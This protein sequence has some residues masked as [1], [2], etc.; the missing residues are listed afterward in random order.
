MNILIAEDNLINQLLIKILM[1]N[2][3]WKYTLVENGFEAIN[4]CRTGSFDAILMDI[5]MPLLNGI[6]AARRIRTFNKSIP[7]I[8]VTAYNNDHNRKQCHLAGMDAFIEKPAKEEE[9]RDIVTRFIAIR[10]SR[11]NESD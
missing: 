10:D 2:L 1:S 6:E 7:I 5:E 4:A 3:E 11:I 8:A 9:I